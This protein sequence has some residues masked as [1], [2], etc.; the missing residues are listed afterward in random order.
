MVSAET[1]TIELLDIVFLIFSFIAFVVSI[2]IYKKWDIN[3]TNQTQYRL[4]KLSFLNQTIIKYIFAIKIPLFLF[5]IY[6]LD[7]LSNVIIG[8][9]CAVGVV[10][11]TEVGLY[12]MILKIV[13]IYTFG[14]WLVLNRIDL[15]YENLPYTKLKYAIYIVLYLFLAVEIGLD[16]YMFNSID[17]SKLVSCCGTVFSSSS[18]SL[19]SGIFSIPTSLLL[20]L[21]YG[22]FIT[23]FILKDKRIIFGVLN[24]AFIMI[25]LISL[26]LFFS[27]YVYELPTHHCPF[28]LLQKD[29]YY[30]GYLFYSLLF[31]GTFFGLSFAFF[32]IKNQQK[33]SLWFNFLYLLAVSAYPISFYLRNGVWL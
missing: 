3:K 2:M 28:C 31:L 11:A 32:D 12:L 15:K 9:M 24:L 1:L 29:Y 8:A 26:I 19:V 16:F 20:T 21:F 4:E 5:F 17:I 27:T 7:K 25:S 22:T 33:F 23:M 14:L 13:N 18:S 30:I 10:N 6:T